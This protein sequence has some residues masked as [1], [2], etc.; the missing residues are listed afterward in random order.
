MTNY[1]P[2][3]VAQVRCERAG[4]QELG[5]GGHGQADP[6]VGLLGSADPGGGQAQ[7]ALGELEGMFFIAA[8]QVGATARRGI[9]VPGRR[10]IAT[11][12]CAAC[13]RRAGARR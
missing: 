13:G 1:E 11:W 8:G 3:G 2:S 4:E 10:A 12:S 5:E 9:A 7:R 6:P